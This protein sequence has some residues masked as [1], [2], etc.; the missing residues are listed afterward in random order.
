MGETNA[1]DHL[2]TQIFLGILVMFLLALSVVIFFLIYQR[3]LL[4]QQEEKNAL[5]SAFQ[6]ELIR[7]G[8]R[9]QE[10]DRS[11]M[12][13]DL[14]DSI[15]GS[16]TATKMLLGHLQQDMAPEQFATF[17]QKALE[18]LDQNLQD[19]RTIINDLLPHSLES[20]GLVVATRQLCKQLEELR[21]MTVVLTCNDPVRFDLDREKALFRILQELIN[22]ALKHSQANEIN[23]NFDFHPDKVLIDYRENGPGFDPELLREKGKKTSLGLKS[24]ASRMT[25]LQGHLDQYTA[26]GQGYAVH[27]DVPLQTTAS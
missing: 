24:M 9:A 6:K 3:K 13:K 21:N 27:I 19:I 7:A 23:L 12:A 1:L 16:L 25:Y 20:Q 18:A 22:N 26:P 5:E 14:H 10:E 4:H 11:R 8:V 2:P 17:H 15:G